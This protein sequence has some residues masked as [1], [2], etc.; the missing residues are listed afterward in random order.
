L[1]GCVGSLHQKVHGDLHKYGECEGNEESVD[2]VVVVVVVAWEGN[3]WKEELERK[4]Q[5]IVVVVGVESRTEKR[6]VCE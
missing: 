5:R 3:V 1:E 6:I 2:V 4:E